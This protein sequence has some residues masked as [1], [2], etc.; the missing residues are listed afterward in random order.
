MN[1]RTQQR[2]RG[3]ILTPQ[4]RQKLQA[5]IDRLGISSE[6][7]AVGKIVEK[8]QLKLNGET[9]PE[10]LGLKPRPFRATFLL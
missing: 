9:L 2:D 8:I 3:L 6:K 5:E 10:I 1:S 4:G 7:Y